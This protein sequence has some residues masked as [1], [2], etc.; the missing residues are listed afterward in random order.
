MFNY[1]IPI[2]LLMLFLPFKMK[3]GLVQ[4]RPFDA[5]VVVLLGLWLLFRSQRL[6]QTRLS[7][8]FLLLI[9]FFLI[10]VL[11]AFGYS[12]QNGLREAL[13]VGLLLSFALVLVSMADELDYRKMGQVMLVGLIIVVIGNIWWHVSHGFWHGWKRIGDP[14]AAFTFLPMVLALVLLLGR[15]DKR[16]LLIG[17]WLVF[18]VVIIMSGE[19][20]ALLSYGIISVALFSSGRIL[21]ALPLVAVGIGT[22]LIVGSL[23]SDQYVS[24]QIETLLNPDTQGLS[25]GAIAAG[26]TP[27]SFSNAQRRFALQQAGNVL[28]NEPL[29]GVGTNAYEDLVVR[30]FGSLP[31]FMLAGVHGDFMR[32]FIENGLVGEIIYLS[33]WII[34]FLNVRRFLRYLV[35]IGLLQQ[36]QVIILLLILF[37]PTLIY[38]AFEASGTRVLMT[39]ILTSLFP[40]ILRGAFGSRL[41]QQ[42][43]QQHRDA[44]PVVRGELSTLAHPG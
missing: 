43:S 6:P 38:A 40:A 13:Q 3:T 8:G 39:M 36:R 19:R 1:F 5:M 15:P 30:K 33:I 31:R 34:S 2:T 4:L 29:F 18:G 9:P 42:Q 37:T 35:G 17:L 28:S 27:L 26:D 11:S 10:H 44:T 16:W 25:L 24:R 41:R 20:K 32:V 14:K 7:V 21:A 12:S 22:L 23:S